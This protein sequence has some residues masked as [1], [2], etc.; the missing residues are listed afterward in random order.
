MY[1]AIKEIGG[2]AVGETVPT[3]KAL[4][5]MD[6]YKEPHIEEVKEKVVEKSKPVEK[7][8]KS[9]PKKKKF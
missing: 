1:K 5:W 4:T 7:L 2:Y 8:S 3:E 6:M 9:I